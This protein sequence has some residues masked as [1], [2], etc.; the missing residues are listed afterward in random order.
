[1][2][3]SVP[4]DPCKVM[5]ETAATHIFC[6]DRGILFADHVCHMTGK[7]R[8]E[9]QGFTLEVKERHGLDRTDRLEVAVRI[10]HGDHRQVWRVH[11]R[12]S[13][14]VL[15]LNRN[16]FSLDQR[17]LQQRVLKRQAGNLAH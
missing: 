5:I 7:N 15:G 10:N 2:L 17:V 16:Q 6:C 14:A 8:K 13:R 9:A 1:M 4:G 12:L 3:F 11:V